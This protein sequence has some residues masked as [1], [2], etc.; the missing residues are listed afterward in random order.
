TDNVI[1][2]NVDLALSTNGGATFP[3][4]IAA[5][6]AN[7]GTFAWTLPVVLTNQAR[8][9]VLAHDGTGN[10]GSDSSHANFSITGWTVT[11]SAGPNGSIAPS[12]SVAVAD[13]ATP[14]FTITPNFGFHVQD[15]LVNGSSVGAV[16]NFTFPAVHSNQT[17]AASFAIN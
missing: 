14:S 16:T 4:A 8:V 10:I 11:A 13:G 7:S 3:T 17:I 6:I 15:V 9:R 1:V 5:G 2:A 12:G